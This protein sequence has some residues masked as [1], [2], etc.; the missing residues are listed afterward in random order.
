MTRSI[1]ISSLFCFL[2]ASLAPSS[3]AASPTKS[4]NLTLWYQQPAEVWEE[5]LAIGNGFIGGMVYGGVPTE[6]IQFN[7]ATFW[8]GGPHDNT[9]PDS[10]KALPEV[11]KLIFDGKHKEAHELTNKKMMGKPKSSMSYQP[12]GDLFLEFKGQEKFTDYRRS[13]NLSTA[14]SEVTYRVGDVHF[15][16]ETFV[17]GVDGVII[18]HLTADKPGSISFSAKLSSI[19][20]NSS[21]KVDAS[22]QLVLTGKAPGQ[23]GIDGVTTFESR[24]AIRPDGGTLTP[25]SDS[26]QVTNANSATLILAVETSFVSF[27]DVSGNPAERVSRRLKAVASRK[28][29][30][31]RTDHIAAH[32]KL[33]NRM[34]IDLGTTAAAKLPTDVRLKNFAKGVA[35]PALAALYCQFGRYL[36]ITSSQPG[37]PP[38]NLQGVW[39]DNPK[40]P[41]K[42]NYTIDMNLQ[43][44]Y[45]PVEVLNLSECHEPMFGYLEGFAVTGARAAK[46]HWGAENGWVA[47]HNSDIWCSAAPH[48]GATWGIWPTGGAWMSTDI[49]THYEFTRDKKFLRRMYPVLKGCAEFFTETL[50]EDP[51]TKW[52]VTCPSISPENRRIGGSISICAGPAMDNQLIRDIFN[53]CAD[54]ADILGLD[55]AFAAKLRAMEKRLPPHQIGEGGYLQEWLDDWDMKVPNKHHR[56]ISHLYALYPGSQITPRTPKFFKAA[57]KSLDLRGDGTT[58][59]SKAWYMN[60]RARFLQP[61]RAYAIFA[62]LLSVQTYPNLFDAHKKQNAKD[63]KPLRWQLFQIDGNF[64]APAGIAEMLLQSH[65]KNDDGTYVIDLLPA[66]PK[67]WAAKGSITGL[68]ARGGFEVD[69]SWD[70]GKL[71][72]AKITSRGG[73]KASVRYGKESLHLTLTDGKS[74]NLNANLKPNKH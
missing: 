3:D 42:S 62:D 40:P 27:Q 59:W 51:G 72:S 25:G 15:R 26:I 30:A 65:L 18:V 34:S 12:V 21:L 56:H 69:L 39:N 55:K 47:H 38:P 73:T 48:D 36:M 9:N 68:R 22:G 71:T 63:P 74:I 4:D 37:G 6:H 58:S 45:W 49:W 70:D 20:K 53:Q 23:A 67:A 19:Q 32:Q 60:C 54:S 64:G 24:L 61:E 28:Y 46:A 41:W 5:A 31:I 17:S 1:L 13:L 44:T 52:L 50:V 16:R 35:D 33:F 66:L 11:R 2:G 43:M 14:I 10:A 7:H 8:S 57:I 29:K